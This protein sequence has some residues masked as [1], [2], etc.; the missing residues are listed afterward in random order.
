MS[1]AEL[2]LMEDIHDPAGRDLFLEA[3]AKK[4]GIT[5][6]EFIINGEAVYDLNDKIVGRRLGKFF[7]QLLPPPDGYA[8]LEDVEG[9][10]TKDLLLEGVR[11]GISRLAFAERRIKKIETELA[12]AEASKRRALD[13]LTAAQFLVIDH[14]VGDKKNLP[15]K[16]KAGRSRG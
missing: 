7:L 3:L 9:P 11:V 1:K 2:I 14:L 10:G 8:L 6:E 5:R 4:L 15:P 12:L 16:G 13:A